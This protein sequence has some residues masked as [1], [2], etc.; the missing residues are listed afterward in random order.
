ME[1]LVASN[2]LL[3][4]AILVL[5]VGYIS[6]LRRV[7]TGRIQEFRTEQHSLIGQSLEDL[8]PAVAGWT[9][10]EGRVP[11]GLLFLDADCA[12]CRTLRDRLA[13]VPAAAVR[14]VVV[15]DAEAAGPSVVARETEPA[16]VSELRRRL[17][18]N[19]SPYLW[20]SRSGRLVAGGVVNQPGDIA[21][22]AAVT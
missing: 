20:I 22:L 18:V 2:L 1:L 9:G 11:I 19:E 10:D 21:A 5:G 12:P 6:L 7:G 15:G 14:L 3:W 16:R 8:A 4:L 17:W 13:E